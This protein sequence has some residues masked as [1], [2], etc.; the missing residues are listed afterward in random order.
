MPNRPPHKIDA[1]EMATFLASQVVQV[2]SAT[3]A[4][5]TQ[6]KQVSCRGGNT[7]LVERRYIGEGQWQ[8]VYEGPDLV[9]ATRFY[10][11]LG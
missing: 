4:D 8:T 6:R 2:A 1:F 7:Y 10:N 11:G 3:T 5:G 9:E